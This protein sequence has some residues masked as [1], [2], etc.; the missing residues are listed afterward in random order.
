MITAVSTVAAT[1]VF[2]AVCWVGL[3]ALRARYVKA[4]PPD[5]ELVYKPFWRP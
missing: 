1:V 5:Q 3:L 2:V 4:H